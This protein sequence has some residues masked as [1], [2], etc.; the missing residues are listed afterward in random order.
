MS[1]PARPLSVVPDTPAPPS[2]DVEVGAL[3]GIQDAIARLTAEADRIKARLRN[4]LAPG[5]H[6]LGGV[7][8]QI[9]A[10]RRFS[11]DLAAQKLTP[12]ELASITETTTAVSATLAKRLLSP[13][14]YEQLTAASGEPRVTIR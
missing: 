1:Q 9:T 5:N 3:V 4:E 12:A 13:I 14:V 10:A 2:L 7:T 11:P 6:A 8:V